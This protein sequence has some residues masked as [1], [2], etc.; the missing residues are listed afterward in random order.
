MEANTYSVSE[1]SR[2]AHVTVRTLHHYDEIGLLVPSQRSAKGYRQY[3]DSDLQRLQ[4]I[5]IFRQLGF[6]LESIQRMIDEPPTDRR[7]A[8]LTQRELLH[9][10]IKET[11]AVIRAIDTAINALEGG[12]GMDAKKMFD[13]FDEFDHTKYEDEARERWGHTEAYK[14]SARRTKQYTKEDWAR[15]KS[16]M[17]SLN[18]R[19]VEVMKSGKPASD[20]A[21]TA[22]AEQHRQHIDRWFYPCSHKMHV[23][24]GEMYISDPRFAENYEKYAVGLAQYMRDAII[25][26]AESSTA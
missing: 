20:A 6:T 10:H 26:N 5:L 22:I 23:G 21:A 19:M 24:L 16:E 3:T 25:A 11:E 8:L 13:G 1:V 12:T 2:L 4:Q 18:Q 15:M 9:G 14:E 17:E 7:E